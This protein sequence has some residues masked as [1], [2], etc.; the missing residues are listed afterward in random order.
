MKA[1]VYLISVLLVLFLISACHHDQQQ[2]IK[3]AMTLAESNPYSALKVLNHMD[4]Q[5]F[6]EP[7]KALFALAYTMAQDKSGLDVDNDSLIRTAYLHFVQCPNDSLY[8]RCMYYMG[9]YYMLKDS[10]EPAL[11]CFEES[12]NTS[13]LLK[14]TATL[15]MAME[16][17]GMVNLAL[18]PQK[19]QYCALMTLDIY[20]KYSKATL[21]NIVYY[22]LAYAQ[23]LSYMDKYQES[24][25]CLMHALQQ[26]EKI[27]DKMLLS[28]TYQCC[29]NVCL[30]FG[31]IKSALIYAE[32]SCHYSPKY[33]TSKYLNLAECY[34]LSGKYLT[35]IQLLNSLKSK[36]ESQKFLANY[37]LFQCH[38]ALHND[39]LAI[40]SVDSA[41][42][43]LGN[44]YLE[45][46]EDNAKYYSESMFKN[47]QIAF[48]KG[49][50]SQYKIIAVL[51]LLLF[52]VT[53]GLILV[54][55]IIKR[56]QYKYEILLTKE[57]AKHEIDFLQKEK[58]YSEKHHKQ[59]VQRQTIMIKMMRNY[60]ALSLKD[61]EEIEVY[62]NVT[63]NNLVMRLRKEFPKINEKDVRFLMLVRLELPAK[64][65]ARIYGICEKSVK[66]NLYLFKEKIGIKGEHIS[67]REYIANF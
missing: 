31:E 14:D 45:S 8:G 10:T 9:K 29:S 47:N 39:S 63:Q 27:G 7:E 33:Y 15:C 1:P 12:K 58:E 59:E 55:L 6:S 64:T 44:M 19:S 41:I 34:K 22:E 28:D 2:A 46:S 24:K 67:L 57:N 20:K 60:I 3:N 43:H 37:N 40:A 50:A 26:A 5:S 51:S 48:T 23:T 61:W 36:T 18:N 42:Q 25:M 11:Y 56:K 4:R 30:K 54:L 62:L 52:V 16:K 49:R 53:T 35:C 21:T 13:I 38:I 65:M 66:Q 17:Y 32:S